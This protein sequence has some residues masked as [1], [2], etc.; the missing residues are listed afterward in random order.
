MFTIRW[1]IKTID[2]ISMIEDVLKEFSFYK[3]N[4]ISMKV[5]AGRILIKSMCRHTGDINSVVTRLSHHPDIINIE[6]FST[7]SGIT[8]HRSVK[9]S[10]YFTDMIGE[11]PQMQSLIEKS[12]KVFGKSFYRIDSR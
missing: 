9:P 2:R 7:D 4:I 10:E 8:S 5:T 11:S 6:H 1:N 12:D 3:F